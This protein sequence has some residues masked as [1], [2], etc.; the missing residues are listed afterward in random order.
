[1]ASSRL[2]GECRCEIF[3][4]E[5][6]EA[7]RESE[8]MV[9]RKDEAAH[10]VDPA[11]VLCR[12]YRTEI[13]ADAE[14]P[15]GTILEKLARNGGPH[16]PRVA[17]GII[18]VAPIHAG[19]AERDNEAAVIVIETHLREGR[20]I[21]SLDF[22]R[23]NGEQKPAREAPSGG[24]ATIHVLRA[25]GIRGEQSDAEPA[26]RIELDETSGPVCGAAPTPQ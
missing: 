18:A 4:S 22:R 17:L 26:N 9:E 21:E 15:R 8:G 7:F 19:D 6:D 24:A 13:S 16:S 1:M 10:R 2:G 11:A 25:P 5:A 20:D 14:R 12:G 3:Q 23:V